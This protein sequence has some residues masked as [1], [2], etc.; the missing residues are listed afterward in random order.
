MLF[1]FERKLKINK[2]KNPGAFD[3]CSLSGPANKINNTELNQKVK[4]FKI[5]MKAL[6]KRIL[7]ILT[8][9]IT[10]VYSRK[11]S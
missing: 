8:S 3:M 1:M 7:I 2:N 9:T 6:G 10:M 11:S 4:H 5:I